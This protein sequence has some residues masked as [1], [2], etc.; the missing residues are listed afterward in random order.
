MHVPRKCLGNRRLGER[1]TKDLAS[2]VAHLAKL[3]FL[4]GFFEHSCP[5]EGAVSVSLWR[6][7]VCGIMKVGRLLL[8][9]LAT[10]ERV[11]NSE[12]SF[13]HVESIGLPA[14][15]TLKA[16]PVSQ[17][18][19]SVSHLIYNRHQAVTEGRNVVRELF[20]IDH[21]EL[22]RAFAWHIAGGLARR[23]QRD[24]IWPVARVTT[25]PLH[26]ERYGRKI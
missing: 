6:E 25:R 18:V 3:A 22:H 26:R 13:V 12:Q 10:L 5:S 17:S 4:V 9:R 15:R 8:P 19:G 21:L 23:R 24:G 1:V 20:R 16:R 2:G 14:S 11:V 7:A